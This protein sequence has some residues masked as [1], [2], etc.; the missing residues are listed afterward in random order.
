MG[1]TGQ[2]EP[3]VD[4]IYDAAVDGSRWPLVLGQLAAHFGSASA[5]L[6]FENV[7]S[8]RGSMIS[9]GADPSFAAS[10]SEYYVTRN[11]LWQELLRRRMSGVMC[12]RQIIPK[13][14]FRKSEFYNDFLA[15]Q[16][17]D[18]LLCA[19]FSREANSGSTITLWRPR[20]FERWQRGDLEHFRKLIPH[21]SR[22]VRIGSHFAAAGAI[23]AFSAEA[24]YRL[25]RGLF[26]VDASA[27]LLFASN[28]AENLLSA[29]DGLH[30]DQ[31]RL[32]A[33]HPEQSEALH[34][35][36]AATAQ[37]GA[38]GNLIIT[39]QSAAPLLAMVIPVRADTWRAIEGK[40][41]AMVLTKDLSRA[42]APPVEAFGSHYGLTPAET[43]VAH[44]LLVGDGIAAAARRLKISEAT[45]RTHR[46]RIFQKTG[47]RRQ[48]ELVRVMLE[49]SAGAAGA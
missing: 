7:Q 44:E 23:N 2:I 38:G 49:W 41:G 6:S 43:R 10:Y 26:I 22:A 16:D 17:C 28:F 5:H 15:P 21:L 46:I 42:S 13:H 39:R 19:P 29:G 1:D 48:A 30:L 18:D 35:L 4:G 27:I 12:D 20:R 31:R 33:R 24:L 9:F 8:T 34:Q 45:A 3:L 11:L 32:S 47:V 36:I 25:G 40:P 14:E 37:R